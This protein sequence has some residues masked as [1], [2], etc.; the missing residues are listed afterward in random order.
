MNNALNNAKEGDRTSLTIAVSVPSGSNPNIAQEIL[1]GVAQAQ[2]KINATGGIKGAGLQVE[3]VNDNNL[4]EVAKEVATAL[5]NDPKIL[6][7]IG[8]NDSTASLAAAPIYQEKGLVR[9]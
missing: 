9:V 3:I 8:H 2:D 1:R 7:V 4:A 6:G 5:T